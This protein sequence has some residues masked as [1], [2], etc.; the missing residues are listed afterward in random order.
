MR[1]PG[2]RRHRQALVGPEHENHPLWQAQIGKTSAMAAPRTL[3]PWMRKP[4]MNCL[5]HV[6]RRKDGR[7]LTLAGRAPLIGANAFFWRQF[8][9]RELVMG[10]AIPAVQCP[11]DERFVKL[12][13]IW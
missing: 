8:S 4:T 2:K 9:I 5:P 13:R 11:V 10:R 6:R 1:L 12:T 7:S 3:F